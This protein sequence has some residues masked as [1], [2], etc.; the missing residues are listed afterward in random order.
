M[1]AAARSEARS[2]WRTRTILLQ[3]MLIQAG[4]GVHGGHNLQPNHLL[5][6]VVQFSLLVG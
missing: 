3:I 1:V 2:S 4:R 6:V 5:L